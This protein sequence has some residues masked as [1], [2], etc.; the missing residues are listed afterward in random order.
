MARPKTPVGE[1]DGGRRLVRR[2]GAPAPDVRRATAGGPR[3]EA[4]MAVALPLEAAG[5]PT[6]GRRP[7]AEAALQVK[8]TKEAAAAPVTA[9]EG[10]RTGPVAR[11]KADAPSPREVEAPRPSRARTA[12]GGTRVRN[13]GA[14]PSEALV[15]GEAV[16]GV[17]PVGRADYA[18]NGRSAI[19]LIRGAEEGKDDPQPTP[20]WKKRRKGR[21]RDPPKD[22]VSSTY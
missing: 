9:Q 1:G 3:P 22:T 21:D 19:W 15:R 6:A 4:V 5:S 20:R 12:T 16:V 8:T 10:A 14:R 2:V 18:V 13:G 17:A 11:P 7:R